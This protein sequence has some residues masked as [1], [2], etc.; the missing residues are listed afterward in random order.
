VT[1]P[2]VLLVGYYGKGNF[3]DDVLLRVTH[4]IVTGKLPQ[5]RIYILVDGSNGDYVNNML[6]DV[7][8]LAPGRHGHFD[9]IVH[10]GGGCF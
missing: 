5:A 10:G 9:W 3:G 8:L 6:G 4:R 7:T 2:R 1:A